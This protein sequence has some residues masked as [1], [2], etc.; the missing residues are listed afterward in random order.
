MINKQK[1][2]YFRWIISNISALFK[3]MFHL[4]DLKKGSDQYTKLKWMI[5]IWKKMYLTTSPEEFKQIKL[6]ESLT[7]FLLRFY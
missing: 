2:T 6:F 7:V 4:R 1:K 5:D 3:Q